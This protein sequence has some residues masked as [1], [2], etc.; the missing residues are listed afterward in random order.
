MKR[1]LLVIVQVDFLKAGNQTLLNTIEGYIANGFYVHLLTANQAN[2][3]EYYQFYEL[4]K[5]VRESLS[6][7][8]FKTTASKIRKS[9]YLSIVRSENDIRRK[10]G[11]V[12][13]FVQKRYNWEQY[14]TIVSFVSG[15]MP[16]LKKIICKVKIDYIYGYEIYGIILGYLLQ[17]CYLK[18]A[19]FIK[20]FQGTYLFPFLEK[21]DISF[22]L[23]AHYIA[24]KCKADLT[25]MAN[26]GTRGDKVIERLNPC[27][28]YLFLMNG[29][30]SDIVRMD[31]I[32]KKAIL[33]QYVVGEINYR[34]VLLSSSRIVN[35]KRVDRCIDIMNIL[36]NEEKIRDILL[37]IIGDGEEK[38]AMKQRVER[39]E[40]SENVVFTGWIDHN[41]LNCMFN[42]AD[43]VL[44]LYDIS[45]LSNTIIEALICGK[46]VLTIDD[47]S[48]KEILKNNYNSILVK[49]DNDLI[50]NAAYEI[51]K[52]H[53]SIDILNALKTS[54]FFSSRN[55]LSW[56]DRMRTE[57][58]SVLKIKR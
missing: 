13:N 39:Y 5:H 52:V 15:G 37:V 19:I 26:D 40:I 20:R 16:I 17:K 57:I 9:F 11:E 30:S 50:R 24:I 8:R 47:G 36:I 1:Q 53:D 12:I 48:T 2:N 27:S 21:W 45:N 22:R 3:P 42:I 35:W 51:K 29:V 25:V 34:M 54:A 33:N 14:L 28:R 4:P 43:L 58:D 41:L 23:P 49:L 46:P 38:E 18:D 31:N 7:Y 55:I 10:S 32:D 6:I 56:K 44:S